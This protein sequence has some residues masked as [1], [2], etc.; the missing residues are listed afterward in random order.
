MS[1][2]MVVTT[3]AALVGAQLTPTYTATSLV[4]LDPREN[5][6]VDVEAV[7]QGMSADAATVETQIKVLSSRSHLEQVM[8]SLGLLS[9]PEFNPAVGRPDRTV[10]L[11]A[12][13]GL[14]DYLSWVPDGWLVATGLAE[15]P[16]SEEL[17]H[18]ER[19]MVETAIDNFARKLDVHQDGRSYVIAVDF[20]SPNPGK[21]AAVANRV[22]DLYVRA[23]LDAKISATNKA[24]GWLGERLDSLREELQVAEQAVEEF[25]VANGLVDTQQG[26]LREQELTDLSRTMMIARA[27]LSEKQARLR[28]IRELRAQG[29]SLDTVA[30][31]LQ[32]TVIV[33]LRQQE[34][35]LIREEAELRTYYGEKHP[36]IQNLVAEKANLQKKIAVEVDRIIKNLGNEV[37]I[38]ESRVAETEQQMGDLAS[39]NDEER[40]L[41][42][43]LRELE[44]EVESS[45][46][47]YESFLQRFKETREQQQI[48]ES[49]VRVISKAAP[50][51][52]PSSPG[53]EIFAGVGFVASLMFGSLLALLLERLDN[54]LRGT[55]QVE[56]ELGIPAL[57]LVPTV[58][59]LK[60]GEHPHQYLIRKPLSAYS[61]ALRAIYTSLKLSDVDNPPKVIMV[62]S[63][64]PQEGK[65]TLSLSLATFAARSSQ[66]VLL[67]DLDLRHPSVH[68]DLP[69]E[70][71]TGFVELISGE[72][73][74]EEVILNEQETGLDILPIKRQTANP[75]D[76]LSSRKMRRLIADLKSRYDFIVID[77]APLLGV[78]DSKIIALL[79]DKVIFA[80]QWEKTKIE[81]AQNGL[82]HLHEIGAPIAGSV[83]TQVN[84]KKHAYY[85]YGDVGQYYGKYQ[86]YYVN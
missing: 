9:D 25:R 13:N 72:K 81:A 1:T 43:E 20:T 24:S 17:A 27:D 44:R 60:R 65:T 82:V 21:A 71:S 59:A 30:E 47:L 73:E 32:S 45:R 34:G 78:T 11:G 79:A 74:L 37:R 2:V 40:A 52:Q 3:L 85:G 22:A 16:V 12:A 4:M 15:E 50:P 67:M 64:L 42:V 55:R 26:R 46:Q 75:T 54:G 77:S 56:E 31:V 76:L 10:R 62:T 29:E 38:I 83:L 53:A 49:D 69:L 68:R 19:L 86:K 28:L 57:G 35:M 18:D 70:P 58:N 14:E 8:E 51:E 63:A 48:V 84:V 39:L 5:R 61:E 6:V 7:L 41:Q 23:Q 36:K 80:T 66:K 33:N